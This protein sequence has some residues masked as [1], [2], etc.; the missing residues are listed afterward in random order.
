MVLDMMTALHVIVIFL[1]TPVG[2]LVLVVLVILILDM[3]CVILVKI[4]LLDV[5]HV[6]R[7]FFVP[8]ATLALFYNLLGFANVLLVF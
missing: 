1:D 6:Q 8:V 2:P 7:L 5:I 3:L 4:L